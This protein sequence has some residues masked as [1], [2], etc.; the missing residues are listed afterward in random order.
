[1][2]TPELHFLGWDK[3]AIELVAEKL[4]AGL[5]NPQSAAE[6]RRATV[7]VPSAESGRR[8]R[9]YMA[10]KAAKPLLMPKITLAGQLIPCTGPQ[11][12]TEMETLAAWM[13]VLGSSMEN[14]PLPWLLEVATQMQRVRKQLEQ[15]A[16]VPEWEDD[17][18]RDFVRDYLREPDAAWENT[19]VYERERWETLRTAFARVDEQLLSWNRQPAEQARTQE[20]E[21]PRSR[22]LLIVACVP[23]LSPLNRLYLQRLVDT[24]N[25]HVEI[26]VNAPAGESMRF[27][28]YG[29]PL[30]LIETGP[31]AGM[32]WSECPIPIPRPAH[33]GEPPTGIPE[34]D[35]IHTTG[36]AAAFGRK[37]RELAGGLNSDD[38]VL[39]SCDSSL[40]PM[41]VSAFLPEWQINMPEGRSLL[42]TEA[43]QLP[44]QL[45]DAC[46]LPADEAGSSTAMENFLTLLKNHTLQS[47]MS[48]SGEL[49]AFNR[50]L[51]EL[52]Y[53]HLPGSTG[54]LCHLMKRMMEEE[55]ESAHPGPW[56]PQQIRH[57]LSYTEHIISLI[58]DCSTSS[59]LPVRL[60]ELATALQRHL[61][62]P[63]LNRAGQLLSELFN[64]TADLVADSNIAYSPQTA[65]VLMAHMAGKQ[66]AGVL[67]GAG[68]RDKVINLRGWREL[69]YTSEPRL[70]IAGMHNGCVPERMQAD[71]Y[72]PNAYRAFLGMTNDA[73][74]CARD[75][76]LLTALLHSR[77]AGEVHFVLATCSTDGTPIAPSPLL[78]RCSTPAETAERVSRLFADAPE[79]AQGEA[80][81][82]L[83]FIRP[84]ETPHAGGN[85]ES[86]GLIARGCPNP[87]ANPEYPFS[88]S[89]IKDF[90]TC[91]L[92]FWLKR[93]LKISPGDALEDSKSEPDAA[94][95][96]T[97]LHA[98]LQDITTRY[99]SAEPG[100]DE[101]T[102]A[103][104]IAAYAT[105]SVAA[106]VA[107]Q[108]GHQSSVLTAP[109][110]ILQR[111][112]CRTAREF[113]RLHARDLCNGWE[114]IMREEQ[115]VLELPAEDDEPPLR[116]DMRVDR[117]DRHRDDVTRMRVIDYKTN[118]STPRETHWD[119]LAGSAPELYASYMP[120]ALTLLDKK[121]N[122]YRWSSVQLP[123]Y[124]EA[125][126]RRFQL[127]TLPET[128]FY[129]MPRNKPGEVK[130]NAMSGVETKSAMTDELHAQALACVR[131][132]AG[133]MRAGLCLYSAESLGRNMSYDSFGALSIYKD[134]DPRV[135]C[136][137]PPLPLP[138]VE[139]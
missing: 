58:R 3:P 104:E 133:L 88:P 40:A 6:Y 19:L 98:I 89:A 24:G 92:R 74:R 85:M 116:F 29:Q 126:R 61:S 87:Y 107:A 41:L 77:P 103:L 137:L 50:F 124:A 49:R 94:E 91:P 121:E 84:G 27:D 99:A 82:Q 54:H 5:N 2:N 101:T 30:P 78:L 115:L 125:M 48:S 56:K 72:L 110:R 70:I 122:S 135:M 111:N 132:A 36:S 45:R 63:E 138:T 65:L 114:V 14:K 112:M 43:G 25:A 18:A 100:T 66:A 97:L 71:A 109:L 11:I 76:F 136:G 1:M 102:L 86:I 80:Y 13:Q 69:C 127:A 8:L 90:L 35:V 21:E 46:I 130:Y 31:Y 39:A 128:G 38:V 10:E 15:E 123:L 9:E 12:A 22:G 59:R 55:P 53:K 62:S 129:N 119:K 20:L 23:E 68:E 79:N 17:T 120:E 105:E 131:N 113:S 134:P 64:H 83:H 33:A 47:I 34:T 57:F 44:L 96:G 26:W 75:S 37:V 67:E 93:V 52:C 108:Y 16:R 73:T 7:V 81:D 139:H 51:T 42:S 60:R 4:L 28:S 32:G 118:K 106:H 117:V 95:Y